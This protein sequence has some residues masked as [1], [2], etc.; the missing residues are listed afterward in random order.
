MLVHVIGH[1]PEVSSGLAISRGSDGSIS[2]DFVF[3]PQ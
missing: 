2:L 1:D 3:C